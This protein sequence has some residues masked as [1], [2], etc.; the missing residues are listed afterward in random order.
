VPGDRDQ[1]D[2]YRPFSEKRPV[3]QSRG[4][5]RAITLFELEEL[6]E[7]AKQDG[8]YVVLIS[9]PCDVC[10]E[11]REDALKPVM[12]N[13]DLKV[14]T[15]LVCDIATAEARVAAPWRP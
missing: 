3:T 5:L 4:A 12:V 10:G 8:K 9:G 13:D 7:L 2:P 1:Q 14:W 6:R 15:H 11:N